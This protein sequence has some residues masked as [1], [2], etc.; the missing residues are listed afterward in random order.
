MEVAG[1]FDTKVKVTGDHNLTL[2]KSLCACVYVCGG[3]YVSIISEFAKKT[4]DNRMFV[5]VSLSVW[6]Y[7]CVYVFGYICLVV[8]EYCVYLC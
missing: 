7:V 4:I 6:L 8:C 1:S 2:L 5:S 3:F